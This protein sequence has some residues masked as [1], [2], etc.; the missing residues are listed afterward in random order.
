M[1]NMNK[2]LCAILLM[3]AMTVMAVAQ[4]AQELLNDANA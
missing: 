3:T 2:R 1:M 4:T